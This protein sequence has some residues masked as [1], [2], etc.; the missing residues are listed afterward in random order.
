[1][2]QG[3]LFQSLSYKDT[4]INVQQIVCTFD[5][6]L[7]INC[8][9]TAWSTVINRNSILRTGFEWDNTEIPVQKEKKQSESNPVL[10]DIQDLDTN[11][12]KDIIKKFIQDDRARNIDLK[13]A[14]LMRV[15]IFLLSPSAFTFIWTFHHAILDG[16]SDRM[17]LE[18]LL[19]CYDALVEDKIITLEEPET[20]RHFA[21]WINN[22]DFTTDEQYWRKNFE[23][24]DSPTP[25]PFIN[26]TD[27]TPCKGESS[28]LELRISPEQKK[29]LQSFV[30]D[31]NLTLNTLVQGVWALLL[32]HYTG[33]KDIIFG[34]TRSCRHSGISRK[35][36]MIGLLI[37]TLPL[38]IKINANQTLLDY[39]KSIRKDNIIL[40]Q[41]ENTPLH[42]IQKWSGFSPELPLFGTIV[43]FEKGSL[44][45]KLHSFNKK[46]LNRKFERYQKT[47]YPITLIIY[48]DEELIV[49]IEYEG[50]LYNHH[51]IQRIM[52]HFKRLL[53][54]MP[55]HANSQAV[56]V[57]YIPE[58]ELN[59]ILIGWNNSSRDYPAELTLVKLF[60]NQVHKTPGATA[61]EYEGL[62]LTYNELNHR[63][64]RLAH[65]LTGLG[66]KPEVPV[67]IF[68][69]RSPEMV[70]AIYGIIKAGGAYVPLD[71]NYPDERLNFMIEDTNIPVI[72][73][74]SH[75][76]E[77]LS[78][79][80]IKSLSLDTE[81]GLFQS[82]SINNPEVKIDPGNMA[83]IIY[84]SGS[85]GKPKGVIN[86]HKGIVNRLLWMQE[87]YHLTEADRVM[88]K[89]PFTFD[90]SVW[91][92]FWPLQT[93]A[94][95][96]IAKP[97]GHKDNSY[98]TGLI[99]E[100]QI[101]T[102][103]FVPS[104]LQLFLEEDEIDFCT[105]LKRVFCSGEALKYEHKQRFFER[106]NA[107]LHNLYGPTE[108]AVD[109][110]YWQCMKDDNLRF[111]PIGYPVANTQ[112]Y[113]LDPDLQPV[114]A[115]CS[116]ELHIGGVQVARGYLNRKELTE[117]KFIPD[118]FSKTP[119]ARLYKTGDL[120]KFLTDGSIEYIGRID[121]QVKI[122]G[123]RVEL[124]EIEN[125]ISEYPGIAQNVVI[126]FED[127]P[128]NQML[129]AY[130]TALPDF[131]IDIAKLRKHLTNSLPD[132]MVPQHY[133]KMDG[134]PLS[135]NGKTD[136]KALP[137]PIFERKTDI[138]Y[139]EPGNNEEKILVGIWK[140][141][142]MLDKVGINDSFFDLGGH[143]LL[144]I[145]MLAKIKPYFKKELNIIDFFRYPSI[146]LLVEYLT[147]IEKDESALS[148]MADM[149]Q[150]QKESIKNK[151]K[152]Q[153]AMKNIKF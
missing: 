142:L 94:S 27:V 149:A 16:R 58:D 20:Y 11:S 9:R 139:L 126:V 67:G 117:E 23:E 19:L 105:S 148:N 32:H 101:T 4:G 77:R 99:K 1:M 54:E 122:R 153:S 146:R 62:R 125:K 89:T 34:S 113:I 128:G 26:Q 72:L 93:G 12:Q 85:T 68:M 140:E 144:L 39:L 115:G 28:V 37:N 150:K 2:Q 80:K 109:V 133:I 112:I 7:N 118:P 119:G 14:P 60:E 35:E 98:L 10:N 46:W 110:T 131:E 52:D 76:K 55:S 43:V 132:Y 88:Q 95:I 134:I 114:P 71:P 49:R 31:N 135:A 102:L 56:K 36:K 40:R 107:E 24:S 59:K 65:Y 15:T 127:S 47:G 17:I 120:A 111:V 129:V 97:D 41:Y 57:P 130:Y 116:G 18:E 104:M 66:I 53:M 92:F 136:R 151:Q 78:H 79:Y 87:K 86:E 106:L 143:S 75:L 103:H 137:S 91:E 74:Q 69:D 70:I 13:T 8:F 30:D 29:I 73:T 3:M 25:L 90:V 48:D 22:Q 82:E 6:P 51:D 83:Y 84:T 141:L 33:R 138:A 44:N 42:L 38:C 100:K 123:L 152:M 81:Q 147:N 50:H 63:S 145:R 61:L 124:G 96:I 45:Y 64:N 21:E 108:A 5:E 121:F